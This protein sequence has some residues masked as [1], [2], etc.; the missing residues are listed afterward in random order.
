MVAFTRVGRSD[1]CGGRRYGSPWRRCID[2]VGSVG[3]LSWNVA[4]RVARDGAHSWPR[5][6]AIRFALRLGRRGWNLHAS[7]HRE[8]GAGGSRHS[9]RRVRDT[10]AGDGHSRGARRR[11]LGRETR[12]GDRMDR[13][14]LP[15][16]CRAPATALEAH[17]RP[18]SLG[19]SKPYPT[20]RTLRIDVAASPSF[21]RSRL[22]WV[23][24]VRV[25]LRTLVPQTLRRS[26]SRD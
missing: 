11:L 26:V 4:V 16:S 7:I 17:G 13:S 8:R 23:S 22:M 2:H 18:R 21:F 15:S 14:R 9:R 10:L 12:Q 6:R 20:P 25:V 19:G 24:T 3:V 1:G 5:R